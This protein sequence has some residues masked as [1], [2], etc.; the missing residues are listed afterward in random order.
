MKLY[1][2]LLEDSLTPFLNR[3][4]FLANPLPKPARNEI[5]S[6]R[7]VD[8]RGT[9]PNSLQKYKTDSQKYPY[10]ILTNEAG[11]ILREAKLNLINPMV[12][13]TSFL[14]GFYDV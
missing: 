7:I 10:L 11:E 1:L 12:Q 3:G 6:F 2:I 4:S 13:V 5:V 9:L 8:I 14:R